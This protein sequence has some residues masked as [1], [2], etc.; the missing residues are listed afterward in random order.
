M[1]LTDRQEG[2]GKITTVR[3]VEASTAQQLLDE[4]LP[5]TEI[6]MQVVHKADG[7]ELMVRT[8]VG[9]EISYT[10]RPVKKKEG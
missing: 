10:V 6:T 5:K 7:F 8:G 2:Q 1:I 4:I 9:D 3:E